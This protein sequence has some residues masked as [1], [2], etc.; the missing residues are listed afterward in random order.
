[1]NITSTSTSG[2]KSSPIKLSTV[3]GV[4]DII[5]IILPTKEGK[6]QLEP[7]QQKDHEAKIISKNGNTTKYELDNGATLIIT[8]NTLNDIIALEMS[9]RGGNNLE[10]IPGISIV[11]G[12]TI[13]KGTKKYK[14]QELARLMEEN[15]IKINVIPYGDSFGIDMKFTRND[16]DLALDIFKELSTKASL[17][18]SD[19]EKSKSDI[20]TSIKNMNNTPE[21]I[22]FDEY[23]TVMWQNTPFGNSGK[24]LEKTI[25]TIKRDDVQNFYTNIFPSQNTV[26]TINGN[27]DEKKFINY[28]SELIQNDETPKI[29]LSKYKEKYKPIKTNK[30][31]KVNK[32]SQ[33][34]WLILGWQTDGKTNEKEYASL[35]IIDAILGSGM[36]SR[37]FTQLRDE[38]SLAYQVGSSYTSHINK[39]AFTLYIATNPENIGTAKNGMLNEIQKLKTEFITDKELSE[40]KDKILGNFVLSQETNMNKCHTLNYLEII[41][42]DYT[43][44][45]KYPEL[46]NSI[47]LQDIIRTANK[48]F[49]RPYIFTIVG[50]KKYID[51]L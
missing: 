29:Q 15:G 22:A 51:K 28:F 16:I 44:I 24:I 9:S 20:M 48:Y 31:I 38:Q 27:V 47:T 41:G 10:K 46:I 2:A 4:A 26:I 43:F 36:S 42:K 11:T 25:P 14:D 21:G 39:G 33:A 5:S 49:S 32:E 37:M 8:Q 18:Y 6:P 13:L 7:K 35:Q 30:I 50:P 12:R 1:M 17:E 45:D 40:A 34:A 23:K 19:I 3:S